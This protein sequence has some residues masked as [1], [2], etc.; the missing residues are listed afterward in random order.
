[1]IRCFFISVLLLFTTSLVWG[2]Q[3]FFP[4][5]AMAKGGSGSFVFG[6]DVQI[7]THGMYAEK[8]TG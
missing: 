4:S 6:K 7:K 8:H 3:A 1:M 2:Q 5:P